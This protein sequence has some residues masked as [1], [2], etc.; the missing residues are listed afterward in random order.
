M[1]H[2]TLRTSPLRWLAALAALVP[3]AAPAA[4][5]LSTTDFFAFARAPFMERA[6]R[7]G[8]SGVSTSVSLS[9]A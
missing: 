5:S 1:L 9:A 8:F 7:S 3:V 6:P 4:E 2:S